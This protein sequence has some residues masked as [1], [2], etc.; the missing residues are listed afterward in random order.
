MEEG[1]GLGDLARSAT[2]WLACLV[3]ALGFLVTVLAGGTALTG[4]LRGGIAA[5]VTLAFGKLL[6]RPLLATILDAM[7]RDTAAKDDPKP[8]PGEAAR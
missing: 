2:A 5:A 4:A 1:S 8:R 7:A 6:V 3:F